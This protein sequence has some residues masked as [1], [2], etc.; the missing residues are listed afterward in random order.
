VSVDLVESVARMATSLATAHAHADALLAA[1]RPTQ[2]PTSPEACD[3]AI[4]PRCGC[5]LTYQPARTT[6]AAPVDP[7]PGL[8]ALAVELHVKRRRYI[9][10]EGALSA[11]DAARLRRCVASALDELN[12]AARAGANR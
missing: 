7:V 1:E 2:P 8:A 9:Q 3:H 6:P 11:V 10:A 12:G 5:G 4:A